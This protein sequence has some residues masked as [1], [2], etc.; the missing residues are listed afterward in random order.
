MGLEYLP[1]KMMLKR[2]IIGLSE[3]LNQDHRWFLGSSN[4]GNVCV[5]VLLCICTFFLG[6]DLS[7]DHRGLS[8]QRL[9][10]TGEETAIIWFPS[11][12]HESIS[13]KTLHHFRMRYL[14]ITLLYVKGQESREWNAYYLCLKCIFFFTCFS[15]IYYY[16]GII[17]IF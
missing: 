13:F 6:R 17:L 10:I 12:V 15:F 11:Y 1:L 9:G 7:G 14:K 8:Q 5:Q 16:N 4:V 2:F 3:G